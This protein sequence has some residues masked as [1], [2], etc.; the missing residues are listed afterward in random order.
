MIVPNAIDQMLF[1]GF[2]IQILP[3]RVE[4]PEIHMHAHFPQNDPGNNKN[5]DNNPERRVAGNFLHVYPLAAYKIDKIQGI[6]KKGRAY[7]FNFI[8]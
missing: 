2:D 1:Q 3:V 4:R 8:Q 6:K 5:P 7:M